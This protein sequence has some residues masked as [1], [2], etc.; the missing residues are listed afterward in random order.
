[1]ALAAMLALFIKPSMKHIAPVYNLTFIVDITRSMN[2]RDYRLNG[3]SVS[4]IEFIKHELRQLLFALPCQSKIGLGVFTDRQSALLFEPLEICSARY[5][6][7]RVLAALDWRMAWAADSRIGKGLHE[8]VTM[9]MSRKT[10]IVF[11]TDG[12]E[13]PPVNPRYHTDFSDVKG[14]SQGMIVGV[15]GLNNVPI[16]K[17]DKEGKQVGIY[18]VDDVP[19]RSTFGIPSR[20]PADA[21]NYHARNAPFGGA[22][23]IGD[24]HMSR[25]YEPHL[26]QLSRE[27]GWSYHRLET[28]DKLVQALSEDFAD[29]QMVSEDIRVYSAVAALFLLLLAYLPFDWASIFKTS[30]H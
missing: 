22:K 6:I 10:S 21:G 15:G 29:T 4:R 20:L 1:M 25:L 27:M 23:V 3:E 28:L 5:E 14:K 16:P 7:D 30:G 8:T 13:A 26:Q 9:L 24:Q 18:S 19:H 11:L 17:Y 12:Q 2:A